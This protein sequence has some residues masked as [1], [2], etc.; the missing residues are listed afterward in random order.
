MAA[1]AM[2]AEAMVGVMAAVTLAAISEGAI[3][4]DTEVV[5]GSRSRTVAFA[6]IPSA[7]TA[8]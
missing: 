2:A 3:S 6:A 4:A 1:E 7:T 5:R 8:A